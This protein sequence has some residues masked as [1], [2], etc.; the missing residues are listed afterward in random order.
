MGFI[1]TNT[2]DLIGLVYAI[3]GIVLVI[4]TC[5]VFRHYFR[6]FDHVQFLYLFYVALASSTKIFSGYL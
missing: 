6:F 5:F 3:A 4:P 1:D 2:M